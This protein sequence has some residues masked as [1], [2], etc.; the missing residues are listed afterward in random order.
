[1][2]ALGDKATRTLFCTHSRKQ[3]TSRAVIPIVLPCQELN[4]LLACSW[5]LRRAI[6]Q[7]RVLAEARTAAK[8]AAAGTVSC[9]QTISQRLRQG[10]QRR[11]GTTLRRASARSTLPRS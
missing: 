8:P 10:L 6:T 3:K 2:A 9:K 1:M 7:S 5:T 11:Q 4:R